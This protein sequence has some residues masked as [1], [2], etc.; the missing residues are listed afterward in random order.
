M[1]SHLT[2]RVVSLFAVLTVVALAIAPGVAADTNVAPTVT[3]T[4][5][6]S[7]PV[8]PQTVIASATFTDPESA[9]ETYTCS[10][11]YGDGSAP[12][13]G[14]LSGTACT[15]PAHQYT[16]SGSYLASVSVTDSGG[17]EGSGTAPVTYTNVAPT[18]LKPILLGAPRLVYS[19]N[20]ATAIT[21][22]G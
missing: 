18:L 4:V 2:R 7:N 8:E 12:V 3:A 14:V 20:A 17:A 22:T 5:S 1:L 21:D 15:G 10:I 16:T 11:D 13:A 6:N 19:V 9:T